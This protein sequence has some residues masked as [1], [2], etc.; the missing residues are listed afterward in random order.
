MTLI[1]EYGKR[2]IRRDGNITGPI[3]KTSK[4]WHQCEYVDSKTK[5]GY[6]RYGK[7]NDLY[8]YKADLVSEYVDKPDLVSKCCG[9]TD[10]IEPL[11]DEELEAMG[12]MWRA[13]SCYICLKCNKAT[14]AMTM[15]EYKS[16]K[17][18]LDKIEKYKEKSS[19]LYCNIMY[20]P[21]RKTIEQTDTE[22]HKLIWIDN[23]FIAR[24][25]EM[26]REYFETLNEWK[27][28]SSKS[29]K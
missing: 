20:P 16:L 9:T 4:T 19:N 14:T 17:D 28:E 11:D 18:K 21:S 5:I 12:S 10:M 7:R 29:N 3:I 1:I 27:N 13:G 24:K 25:N 2:Y 22:N 6:N 26:K 8:E 15:T 23:H